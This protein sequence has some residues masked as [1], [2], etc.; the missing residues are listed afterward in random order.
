MYNDQQREYLDSIS[1]E[2]LKKKLEKEKESINFRHLMEHPCYEQV[3]KSFLEQASKP[4]SYEATHE[5]LLKLH[6]KTKFNEG[7]L[8]FFQ[9]VERKAKG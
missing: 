7:L 6:G 9:E 4:I 3:K 5:G 2:K 8:A 1:S